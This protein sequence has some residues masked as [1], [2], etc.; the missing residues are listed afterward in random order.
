MSYSTE[1]RARKAIHITRVGVV[2]NVVLTLIKFAAALF[3]RSSALLADAIHS[4]TD[5]ISDIVILAG[6]KIASRPQDANHHYGH[7]KFE[8]LSTLILTLFLFG[9]AMGMLWEG[10]LGLFHSYKGIEIPVP[11]IITLWV[12]AA[13]I[14]IKELLFQY[15]MRSGKNLNSKALITNAWH[16]RSDA[17][18]SVAVLAGLSG[19]IFLG[20]GWRVLDPLIALGISGYIIHFA[21][22]AFKSAIDEL[23]DASLDKETNQ[24]ILQLAGAVPG[25][26]HPHNLK[27]RK[28]GNNISIDMHIHVDETLSIVEAHDIATVVESR[29]KEA[30]GPDTILSIHIEPRNHNLR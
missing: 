5:F 26:F 7:G 9:A 15:T 18:T 24:N 14:I 6:L 29:L 27:T 19:A 10:G 12:A 21:A 20:P 30:Y 1:E 22:G 4:F 23:L 13:S 25:V 16:H 2:W 17:F 28:I 3:G 11:E 8:T